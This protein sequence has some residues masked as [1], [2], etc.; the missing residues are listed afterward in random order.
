MT[1]KSPVTGQPSAAFGQ[2]YDIASIKKTDAP[3]G[4]V[5]SDWHRYDIVQG[6]N[7][8]HGFRQGSLKTVTE[9]VEE[10]VA[11]LNERRFGKR[12]RANLAPAAKPASGPASA[13][14]AKPASST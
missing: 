13:P 12:G 1:E 2:P 14:A 3:A 6:K 11:Q 10:I 9:S 5:G 8:F 4:A 7:T